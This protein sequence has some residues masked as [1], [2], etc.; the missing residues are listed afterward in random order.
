MA[1]IPQSGD[2]DIPTLSGSG[3]DVALSLH[4]ATPCR[5]CQK[6]DMMYQEKGTAV[7]RPF[8]MW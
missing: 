3:S 7:N 8:A 1:L 4:V 6:V 2:S 5:F